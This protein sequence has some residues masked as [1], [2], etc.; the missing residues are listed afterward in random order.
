MINHASRV[1]TKVMTCCHPSWVVFFL[2]SFFLWLASWQG[3]EIAPRDVWMPSF[4][5]AP[6][7][8]YVTN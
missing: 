3:M 2:L 6:Y 5:A 7:L 1:A 8:Q 4:L